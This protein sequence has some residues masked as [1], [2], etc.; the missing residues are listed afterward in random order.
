LGIA[1]LSGSSPGSATVAERPIV[2]SKGSGVGDRWG[3]NSCRRVAT[4]PPAQKAPEGWRD[5]IELAASKQ[6]EETATQLTRLADGR[7]R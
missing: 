1:T 2:A 6:R 3:N 5:S 4:N 7:L